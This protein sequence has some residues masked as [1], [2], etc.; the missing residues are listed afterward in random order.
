MGRSIFRSCFFF[1]ETFMI[2]SEKK[3]GHSK[4]T[5]VECFFDGQ[6][7]QKAWFQGTNLLETLFRILTH[8]YRFPVKFQ[9]PLVQLRFLWT[10]VVL[11]QHRETRPIQGDKGCQTSK[12]AKFQKFRI[13]SSFEAFF[14]ET[15]LEIKY[16]LFKLALLVANPTNKTFLK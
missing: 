3:L 1:D 15:V 10:M 14:V 9:R 6:N 8:F 16:G 4:V 5:M 11:G 12:D 13:F 7:W 2:S